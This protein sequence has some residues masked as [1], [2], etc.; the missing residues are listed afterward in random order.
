MIYSII[1]SSL[2]DNSSNNPVPNANAYLDQSHVANPIITT[3]DQ[4][5]DTSTDN[6]SHDLSNDLSQDRTISTGIYM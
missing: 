4:S 3:G 2:A 1:F 5:H 6:M